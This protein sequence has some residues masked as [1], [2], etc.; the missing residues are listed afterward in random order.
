MRLLPAPNFK[1]GKMN[2]LDMPETSYGKRIV[3]MAAAMID[4]GLPRNDG[5]LL[6]AIRRL[7]SEDFAS[8]VA[9][10]IADLEAALAAEKRLVADYAKHNA[11][12]IAECERLREANQWIKGTPPKDGKLYLCNFK[13]GI[14]AVAKWREGR[15]SEPQSN[16]TD[17]RC[18][19]CGRF[20][21]PQYYKR[22]EPPKEA[23]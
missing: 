4:D 17:Y 16:V 19:C 8:S 15:E 5:F 7:D 6:A 2:Y 13:P 22:V 11:E 3:E 9:D 12:L 23:E 14:M 18:E 20:S 10:R 21:T 1:E